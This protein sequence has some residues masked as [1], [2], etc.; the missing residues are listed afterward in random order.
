[1]L[2]ALQLARLGRNSTAPNPMVGAVIV[3]QG[4]IIGEGY[5][6]RAGEGH[7]EVNAI[8]SV[9]SE[10]LAL[11]S[12]STIYVTLEPCSHY[13]R[14]P[15]CAELIVRHRI[16]RCVIG[17]VDPFPQVS[18]RGIELL[19]QAGVVV[20]VGV[21]EEACRNLNRQFITFHQKKR[22]YVTLKWAR[23]Q[24]GYIDRLR[25]DGAA[26]RL[27]TPATTLHV[28][29]QR[30]QHGAILVGHRT[31]LLDHPR[32][33]VRHWF[34]KAP[35]RLVLGHNPQSPFP[36]DVCSVQ[37]IDEVFS[38]LYERGI[39]SLLVEGGRCTL[40]SFIDRGDWDEAWEECADMQLHEGVKAPTMPTEPN[41]QLAIWGVTFR[42]WIKP[43][44]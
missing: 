7:A 6:I 5:H 37:S 42:H 1:M 22:P 27:S 8:K 3:A 40:Q 24:D 12:E 20:R 33:D 28:H 41:E 21:L 23:S 30:A 39:Q 44:R 4:R 35:L 11:L 16:A 25:N 14:T 38:T 31:W 29:A 15:P 26:T 34:G 10:D 17:C 13:G 43:L 36:A 19:R 18:G 2:R 32:L 9:R